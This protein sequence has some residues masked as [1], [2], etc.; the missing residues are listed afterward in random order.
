[1]SNSISVE[2]LVSSDAF[3]QIQNIDDKA[4]EG[5]LQSLIEATKREEDFFTQTGREYST[6]FDRM[7]KVCTEIRIGISVLV[8]ANKADPELLQEPENTEQIDP[9]IQTR[10]K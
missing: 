2:R 3:K 9:S 8:N 4:M 5:D 1:M 10:L 6:Y 7:V